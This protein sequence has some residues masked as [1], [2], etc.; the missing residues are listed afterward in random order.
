MQPFDY[1]F[2]GHGGGAAVRVLSPYNRPLT[3]DVTQ[4]Q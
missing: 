2:G 3:H 4:H 1:A